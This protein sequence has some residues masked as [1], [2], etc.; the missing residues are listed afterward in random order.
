MSR[1]ITH[2]IS[3]LFTVLI[4]LT[5]RFYII[6]SSGVDHE[7]GI[8]SFFYHS[9][10]NVLIKYHTFTWWLHPL[11]L[12]GLYPYSDTPAAPTFVAQISLLSG[13]SV[14]QSILLFD[15]FIVFFGGFSMYLLSLKLKKSVVFSFFTTVVYVSAPII[16]LGTIWSLG[17]REFMV[18]TIP[19]LTLLL[20]YI[21]KGTHKWIMFGLAILLLFVISTIHL[22]FIFLYG[23]FVGMIF[24]EIIRK[25]VPFRRL[26]YFFN[27]KQW[28]N[29]SLSLFLLLIGTYFLFII[30]V[31][32]DM[33]PSFSIKNYEST[34]LFKGT[35]PFIILVN[36][37]VS[38]SGGVG[39]L[40]PIFLP[41]GILYII[42]K[43]RIGRMENYLFWSFLFSL[44][45][46][47][48]RLYSRPVMVFL[49]SLFIGYGVWYLLAHIK[50]S[51]KD[52]SR[53]I[54]ISLVVFL[55]LSSTY[56]AIWYTDYSNTRFHKSYAVPYNIDASPSTY[57]LGL[58][59]KNKLQKIWVTN[60]WLTGQRIQAYSTI[61]GQPGMAGCPS[62]Q[63][64]PVYFK[65]VNNSKLGIRK[66]TELEFKYTHQIYIS[67]YQFQEIK[68][69]SL[70]VKSNIES[71]TA[72]KIIERYN[73]YYAI[74]YSPISG[75]VARYHSKYIAQSEFF[76]SVDATN[77]VIFRNQKLSVYY[78]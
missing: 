38:L 40:L 50:I 63:Y 41:I 65:L 8:D 10:A 19:F 15:I 56:F 25:F 13:L 48:N 30:N 68:D 21:I 70:L 43:K 6:I 9:E 46:L 59:Q 49:S 62:L 24:I 12:W 22:T 7:I 67:T 29:L 23:L 76:E 5:L 32:F 39:I 36:I 28:L 37:G 42:Y 54:K 26:K 73:I 47:I 77:F 61:P 72:Q 20:V 64:N 45:I 44:P 55:L 17:E 2:H 1:K 52:I 18:Y 14:E 27:R 71:N 4:A 57:E 66:S 78:I 75:R 74:E 58:Y 35:N 11:S 3:L 16:L 69:Y 31:F 34:A 33:P 60:D 51:R 53:I